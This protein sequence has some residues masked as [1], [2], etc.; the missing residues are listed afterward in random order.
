MI[1]DLTYL[2]RNLSR[3]ESVLATASGDVF[4]SHGDQGVARLCPDGRQFALSAPTKAGGLPVLA[5]GIALRPDGS[6]LVANIADGGGL[7]ELDADG[8][9]LWQRC[10][11][12][13]DAP[14]VNFV[15]LDE[16]GKIWVTVSSTHRPRSLAYNQQTAN[17][18]VGV[19]EDGRFRIVLDG[20]AYTNEI[21][22]DYAGGWLYIA[23]TMGQKISRVRLDETGLHGAPELFAQMP[24][25]AFVDGIE[26]DSEG[27]VLAACI[28]SSE[29]IRI[30]PDGAQTVIAGERVTTWTDEVQSAFEAGELARVHLDTSPTT[31]L[32]NIASLAFFGADLDRIVFGNLLDDKL[33]CLPSV[34]AGRAPVHWKTDVPLWGTE[35]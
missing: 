25:G 21:R 5:N 17:G 1:F 28:I 16:L 33:P 8:M 18:Y 10:T 35:F 32:R 9:R 3:P 22:A 14:P 34:V 2:G 7:M 24:P 26:I 30:T 4:C 29:L 6:F 23:E 19:I 13:P 12:G 11:D 27:A 31:A 15:L 20:L